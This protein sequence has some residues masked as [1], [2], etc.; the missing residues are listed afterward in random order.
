MRVADYIMK[1]LVEYGVR[2]IFMVT[3]GGSIFLNDAVALNKDLTGIFCHHEIATTTAAEAYQR[4]KGGIGVALVTSGPGGTNA[5]T[6][7]AGAWLDSVPQLVISGQSFSN[8]TIQNTVKGLELVADGIRNEPYTAAMVAYGLALA[9]SQT[10][11]Y[12]IDN[13]ESSANQ[14]DPSK[15]FWTGANNDYYQSIQVETAAWA[16]LAYLA[17]KRNA[18]AFPIASWLMEQQNSNGGFYTTTVCLKFYHN[19]HFKN[20]QTECLPF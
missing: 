7:T 19:K 3:G 11:K 1:R 17:S 6:G 8:Q 20:I 15:K 4:V 16:L 9:E 12:L 5:I 18:E 10:A 13:L 14:S 2:E